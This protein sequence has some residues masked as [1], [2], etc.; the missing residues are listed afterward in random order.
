MKRH[1]KRVV[2]FFGIGLVTIIAL[3]VLVLMCKLL[4]PDENNT[5]QIE[6]VNT[7]SLDIVSDLLVPNFVLAQIFRESRHFLPPPRYLL[8]L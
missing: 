8:S 7:E 5:P 6:V 2:V 3:Y 4:L 1:E